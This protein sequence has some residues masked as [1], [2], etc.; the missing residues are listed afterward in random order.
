MRSLLG[1]LGVLL[2]LNGCHPVLAA[3][4]RDR[5]PLWSQ[6]DCPVAC[7]V[8]SNPGGLVDAFRRAALQMKLEGRR[9]VIDGDCASA[10]TM[11]AD[12]A[13]PRVCITKRAVLRFHR[14]YEYDAKGRFLRR[15]DP[16]GYYSPDIVAWVK[17]RGGF[18][19][20]TE[21]DNALLDMPFSEA[22][23]MFPVCEDVL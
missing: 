10:C 15:S 16:S 17:E 3:E 20:S 14:A 5:E 18:P 12:L 21:K 22:K 19:G 13:R 23:A 6:A 11:A 2:S 8:V 4:T 9:L 7:V 1:V